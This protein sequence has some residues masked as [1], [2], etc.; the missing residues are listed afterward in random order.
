MTPAASTR[1][2]WTLLAL[3]GVV[4][5]LTSRLLWQGPARFDGVPGIVTAGYAV[6]GAL[7]ASRRPSSTFGWLLL[8]VALA[9]GLESLALVYAATHANPGSVAVA[10]FAQLAGLVWLLLAAIFVLLLDPD[11]RLLSRNWRPVAWF[12]T[13]ALALAIVGTAFEP[14]VMTLDGAVAYGVQNPL[15]ASG[16]TAELIGALTNVANVLA[17]VTVLLAV[18]SLA[19]RFHRGRAKER[20]QLKWL[21]LV[22]GI[23]LGGAAVTTIHC[24][25]P[26]AGALWSPALAGSPSRLVSF[27]GFRR[28]WV[29]PFCGTSCMTLTSSSIGRWSTSC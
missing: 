11:G 5:G 24:Q 17:L 14:G 6:V 22:V 3:Y 26:G 1:L 2:A 29:S 21:V 7:V 13:V 4:Q 23:A 28:R 20:Q 27:S 12:G 8:T 16:T 18:A 19:M 10:G 9:A 15:G 25:K